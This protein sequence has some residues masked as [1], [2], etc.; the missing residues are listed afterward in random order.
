MFYF[1]CSL[2][3][4]VFTLGFM[5]G[6]K[7]IW[8]LSLI[9]YCSHASA[10]SVHIPASFPSLLFFPAHPRPKLLCVLLNPL[11]HLVWSPRASHMFASQVWHSKSYNSTSAQTHCLSLL[12]HSSFPWHNAVTFTSYLIPPWHHPHSPETLYFLN[13]VHPVGLVCNA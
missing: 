4:L 2:T 10:I 8:L 5:G 7:F 1:C 6:K 9:M 11:T 3:C 12:T 13:S